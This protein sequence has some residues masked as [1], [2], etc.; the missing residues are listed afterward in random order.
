MF[1]N[2]IYYILNFSFQNF[3]REL[4]KTLKKKR[5]ITIFDIGCYKGVFFKKF[6]HSKKLINIK[7]KFH[8]FD[9]NPNVSKYLKNYTNKK[10]IIYNNIALGKSNKKKKYNFNKSFEASGSSLSGLYKDD[11]SWIL[12]RELFLKLFLQKTLGYTKI[13]VPV[14]TFDSYIKKNKIKNVDIVKIDVDG[15]EEDVINGMK[16]SLN[17]GLINL[18]QLEISD[19]K[20]KFQ[21]KQQRLINYLKKKNFYLKDS[22][23]I[24]SVSL[25]SNLKCTENLFILKK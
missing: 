1:K 14:C 22:K 8:I 5:K 24:T 18:I 12:S 23:K 10:N 4:F 6:Y 20:D 25:L 19:K 9:I 21:K 16:N 2:F 3:D 7:K 17:K 13:E 11:K 15:S